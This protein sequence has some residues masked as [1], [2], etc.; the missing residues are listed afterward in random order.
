MVPESTLMSHTQ[1]LCV[2]IVLTVKPFNILKQFKIYV[3]G[4]L[5]V[6]IFESLL[7]LYDTNLPTYD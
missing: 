4:N 7:L 6:I 2:L 3:L 1:F 5:I